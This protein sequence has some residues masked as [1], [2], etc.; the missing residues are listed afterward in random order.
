MRRFFPADYEDS[1][2]LMSDTAINASSDDMMIGFWT[3]MPAWVNALFKVRNFLVRFVGLKG[4]SVGFAEVEKVIREGGSFGVMEVAAKN[5]D[6]TAVLMR[7]KHLDAY[8]SVL[9]NGAHEV[10]VNTSVH[11]NNRLGKVYFFFIRPFHGIIVRGVLKRAVRKS[12]VGR[13]H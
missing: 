5:G 4:G 8:M 1:Y 7:D 6:E 2:L 12:T 11:Y 13:A 10:Y 3:D 9:K